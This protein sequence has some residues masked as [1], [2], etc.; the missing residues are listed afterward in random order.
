M[1]VLSAASPNDLQNLL[2]L[3]PVKNL[4]A[5]WPHVKGSK[6]EICSVVA[7]GQK[8]TDIVAFVNQY[9][10]CCKQHVHIFSHDAAVKK[11][12]VA[13]AGGGEGVL[14]QVGKNEG[15]ALYLYWSEFTAVLT[16]PFEKVTLKFLWPVR[17]DFTKDT[18]ILRF[19]VLEKNIS[20]HFN[21]REYIGA[22]KV[23]DEAV[24]LNSLLAGLECPV[25]QTDVHKGLKKLWH[26]GLIDC[27]RVRYKKPNSTATEVMD[28]ERGIK[29]RNPGL[30]ESLMRSPL[31]SA[32]F[33]IKSKKFSTASV[34]FAEPSKGRLAFPRY[35]EDEGD[36][37]NVV[38]EILRLN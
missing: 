9:F 16:E 10:S 36:T 1:A 6:E 5:H 18:A 32:Q 2:E 20:A 25:S 21:G 3:F 14:A 4:K 8:P 37:D 24:V 13:G 15:S 12:P 38:R 27:T 34:F 29:E 33:A 11:A 19:I 28:E 31:I 7:H 30:Y 22:H 26:D 17:F 35:T 23:T